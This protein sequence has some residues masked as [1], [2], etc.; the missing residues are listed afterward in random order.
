MP[1]T[2]LHRHRVLLDH[3]TQ[4]FRCAQR[5]FAKVWGNQM[6][7]TLSEPI[8]SL[9]WHICDLAEAARHLGAA[10]TARWTVTRLDA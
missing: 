9:A 5:V 4:T 8:W 3:A 2:Y 1:A 6:L 7:C 10:V